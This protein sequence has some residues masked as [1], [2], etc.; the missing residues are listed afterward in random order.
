[1]AFSV[2]IP[3]G[4]S[5]LLI[6]VINSLSQIKEL[7]VYV[8]STNRHIPLKYSRSVHKLSYYPLEEN[9]E[10]WIK[11]INTES[12]K[13]NVD[14]IMPIYEKGIEILIRHRDKISN[15]NK[16]VLLPDIEDFIKAKDKWLLMRHLEENSIAHP[17]SFLLEKLDKQTLNFPFIVKPTRGIG[18]G[19][20]ISLIKDAFKLESFCTASKLLGG[21]YIAQEYV[22]GYDIGCSVLCKSGVILAYTI[23]KASLKADN[24][25]APFLGFD[26]VYEEKLYL[27]I[28][29]LMKS[30]NWSGV[31]HVDTRYD[32]D[33]KTFKILEINTR[34]WGSLDASL[35]AGVNFPYLYCLAS[36]N[37]SFPMP[38]YK[39]INCLNLKG[40][41]KSL[42]SDVKFAFRWKFILNNT[43]LKFALNDPAPMVYKY[44]VR[45]KNIMNNR[46]KKL[47]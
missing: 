5:H 30:L 45:T 25:F 24:P 34:F 17:K 23:Q 31:A 22:N 7:K 4:E 32:I 6:Y 42:K 11:S 46:L 1:M 35:L 41:V 20:N 43:S 33:E 28:S 44:I 26:F 37:Q 16:L 13:Y 8:M 14:L 18:G 2:L 36:L 12:S 39:T 29:D 19:K 10:N 9:E 21:E 15:N 38:E 47:F 40:I 3:D 27:L